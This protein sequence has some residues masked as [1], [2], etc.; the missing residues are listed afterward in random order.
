M[1]RKIKREKKKEREKATKGEPNAM[2]STE[3]SAR[4]HLHAA[5]AFCQRHR[6]SRHCYNGFYVSFCICSLISVHLF[7]F[8]FPFDLSGSLIFGYTNFNTTIFTFIIYNIGGITY[9]F[10]A[11]KFFMI[12]KLS[13]CSS[14]SRTTFAFAIVN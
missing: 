14:R 11:H 9:N 6:H 2:F 12:F 5:C 7:G 10:Y 3:L 8:R 4:C 13:L 1:K